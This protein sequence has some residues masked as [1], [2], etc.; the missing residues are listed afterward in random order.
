MLYVF[1]IYKGFIN[2]LNFFYSLTVQDLKAMYCEEP[3]KKKAKLIVS[4]TQN[5]DDDFD[6]VDI[7]KLLCSPLKSVG[8]QKPCEESTN[9]E[10]PTSPILQMSNRTYKKTMKSGSHSKL[11]RLSKFQRTIVDENNIVQSRFFNIETPDSSSENCLDINNESSLKTILHHSNNTSSAIS[12]CE[13]DEIISENFIDNSDKSLLKKISH[14]SYNISSAVSLSESNVII[15]KV[16]NKSN[17]LE[18]P[19]LIHTNSKLP[20]IVS[21]RES[22]LI[23]TKVYNKSNNLEKPQLI[24]TNSKL[25][26][27][28]LS[29]SRNPF[30]I[31]PLDTD[32]IL[33]DKKYA[34]DL[35]TPGCSQ[36]SF[37][38]TVDLTSDKT[39]A[40]KLDNLESPKKPEIEKKMTKSQNSS[41]R[42]PGLAKKSS[43]LTGQQTLLSV[44]GFQKKCKLKH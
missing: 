27:I 19:Q 11:K 26:Q 44:F 39:I 23:V 13:G 5:I 10:E 14:S 4:E 37:E 1:I 16:Y 34:V 28:L 9:T 8:N 31:A 35:P 33:T 43:L 32:E 2:F 12:S 6:S 30:K 29:P 22:N 15:T 42:R 17:N 25:P 38:T 18:I 36:T 20:Q 40:N 7:H 21:P 24:H 41:C 3:A